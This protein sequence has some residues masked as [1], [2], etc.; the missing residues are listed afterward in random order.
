MTLVTI[1]G[2]A[3]TLAGIGAL[4]SALRK[5]RRRHILDLP[6]ESPGSVSLGLSEVSGRAE[7]ASGISSGPA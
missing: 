4:A 6:T 3:F 2:I 5:Y 7:A 1:V